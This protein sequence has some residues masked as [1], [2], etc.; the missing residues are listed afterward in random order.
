MSVNR[1]IRLTGNT[2]FTYEQNKKAI[3]YYYMKRKVH[4]D[5]I[6][7]SAHD[8]ELQPKKKERKL[9]KIRTLPAMRWFSMTFTGITMRKN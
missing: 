8:I 6:H 1:G 5:S 2:L 7:T 9:R 4:D 3:V